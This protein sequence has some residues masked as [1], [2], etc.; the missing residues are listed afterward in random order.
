MAK[1]RLFQSLF[2]LLLLAAGLKQ[3][4][5]AF[6]EDW[7]MFDPNYY[8]ADTG[9][10]IDSKGVF[11]DIDSIKWNNDGHYYYEVKTSEDFYDQRVNCTDR[12]VD[13]NDYW[14]DEWYQLEYPNDNL[15]NIVCTRQKK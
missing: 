2:I 14:T 11:V 8:D 5:P 13:G 9:K 10:L 1:F 4:M 3:I 12:T 7:I 15:I 6:A